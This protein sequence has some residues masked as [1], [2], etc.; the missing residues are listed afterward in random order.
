MKVAI[1]QA[2]TVSSPSCDEFYLVL[3]FVTE[4]T[5]SKAVD[6]LMERILRHGYTMEDGRPRDIL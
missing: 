4:I 5:M 6:Y 3:V 1:C 2:G